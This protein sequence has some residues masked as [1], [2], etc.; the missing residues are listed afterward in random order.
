M[1]PASPR[2][3]IAGTTSSSRGTRST[4][5]RDAAADRGAERLERHA[6]DRLLAGRIDVGQHDVVGRREA[7]GRTRRSATRCANTGAAGTRRRCGGR[8]SAPPRAPPRSRSGDGRSRRRRGCRSA[9]RARRSAAPRRG[10]PSAR[11][12]RDRTV[13]PSSMPTAT[14]ASAFSR[15]WRPGTASVSV[16]SVTLRSAPVSPALAALAEPRG[17]AARP[18]P[19]TLVSG[20]SATSVRGQRRPPASRG[21]RS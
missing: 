16:P 14:A 15:L 19:S 4:G 7:P 11:R 6:G 18:S 2:A 13:S 10:T 8:G 21:R 9:R 12:R 1:S 17:R 3:T 20:P 5:T